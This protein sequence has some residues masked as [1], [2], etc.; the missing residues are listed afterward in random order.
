MNSKNTSRRVVVTGMGVISP[1]GLNMDQTWA[2]LVAGRS[3]VVPVTEFDVSEY[4]WKIAATVKDF[5]PTR[6]MP[7]K[8]ARRMGQHT[9]FAIA[10]LAEAE[11]QAGIDF[12]QED[13][14]RVGISL[15]SGVGGITIIEEQV[16]ILHTRGMRRINPT[17]LPAILINMPACQLA[18]NIGAKGPAHAPVGACASGSLAIGDAYRTI[19]R[20]DVDVMVAGG[21]EST[22]TPIGFASF[23]RLGALSTRNDDPEN[24]CQ[25]FDVT[26]DGTIIGEGA[27]LLILETLEHAQVRGATILAEIAGYGFTEDAYH[28]VM[29]D[30]SGEGSARSIQL[31]MEE[32]GWSPADLDYVCPHGTGT[33]LNDVAETIAIKRALGDHAYRVP[34]SSNKSM[35][36]HMMGAAGAFSACVVIK[37]MLEG[38]ITPTSNLQNPDPECDLDYVPRESRPAEVHTAIVNAFGFG[39]QNA[40]IAIQAYD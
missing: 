4:D 33:P 37:T 11:E 28:V 18:V 14:T 36:G 31:A 20:G 40:T 26:R 39:G 3:G 12:T 5:D 25:P 21:I 24:A 9:Q 27:A 19:Q 35:V 22:I 30:P 15:G 2:G 23:G 13:P 32:A 1:L 6:Y 16:Q 7:A 38:I 17:L 29:P 8:E 10:A 34:T